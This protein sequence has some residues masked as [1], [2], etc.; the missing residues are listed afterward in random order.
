ML[1]VVEDDEAVGTI[2]ML[3]VLEIGSD[4]DFDSVAIDGAACLQVV[5]HVLLDKE[6]TLVL[7]LT[8]YRVQIRN[9]EY[10]NEKRVECTPCNIL[11]FES[12]VCLSAI[13]QV[14]GPFDSDDDVAVVG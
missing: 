4:S 5:P 1:L 10:E 3:T 8:G 11:V 14:L 9:C 7:A 12:V 13:A 6:R 2:L